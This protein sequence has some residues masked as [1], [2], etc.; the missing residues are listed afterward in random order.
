MRSIRVGSLFLLTSLRSGLG[1]IVRLSKVPSA[2]VAGAAHRNRLDEEF[3]MSGRI[4]AQ[5]AQRR[6]DGGAMTFRR[7]AQCRRGES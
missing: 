4:A 5:R 2:G 3:D 6:T 1:V 7:H